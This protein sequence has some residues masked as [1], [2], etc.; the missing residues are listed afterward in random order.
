MARLNKV[1]LMGNLAR[2]PE[3]RYIPSGTPVAT[4]TLATSRA[5]TLASG[6]K[7]EETCFAR[8]V[9]W[10][11]QAELCGEYLAK[12]SPVFVEGRLQSRSWETPEGQKRSTMEVV[13]QNVQFLGKGTRSGGTEAGAPEEAFTQAAPAPEETPAAPSDIPEAPPEGTSGEVPF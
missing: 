3:L 13:A 4:F 5:Y 1:F 9:A 8:V 11:R 6:E 10:G 2:D 12:G 7:R